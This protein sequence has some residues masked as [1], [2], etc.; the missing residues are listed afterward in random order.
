MTPGVQLHHYCLISNG[1]AATYL[2]MGRVIKGVVLLRKYPRGTRVRAA[3]SL[4]LPRL[5]EDWTG[6][7]GLPLLPC[8]GL[9]RLE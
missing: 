4:E 3:G 1:A 8:V 5:I 6:L 9:P 2:A 7:G